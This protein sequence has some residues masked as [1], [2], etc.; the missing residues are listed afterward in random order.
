MI[1]ALSVPTEHTVIDNWMVTFRRTKTE[2]H[3]C[4]SHFL[5]L[6]KSAENF[7]ALF[8]PTIRVEI[9]PES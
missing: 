9:K 7:E 1:Q 3:F 6:H 4:L 2:G 5:G 8:F